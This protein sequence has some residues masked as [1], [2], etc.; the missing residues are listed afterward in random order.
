MASPVPVETGLA[1]R[2]LVTTD[3]LASQLDNPRLAVIDASYYLPTQ[4][5]D[6]A[7]E[8]R[9]AHIPGA[10]FFDIEAI[11]DHASEL[12]HMLPSADEFAT[13]IGGLGIGDGDT[14][15]VYDANGLFS[16]ARV[17]WTFR[18]FG[19]ENVFILDG[20]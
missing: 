8:H 17:W 20:G 13:A 4:N 9:A 18:V 1:S 5:R 16:A 11:S 7:A 15:V 14:V 19:A 2:W 6:A 3:W 10:V 12:P